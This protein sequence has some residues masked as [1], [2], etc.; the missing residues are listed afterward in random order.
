MQW[1]LYLMAII[2]FFV[3]FFIHFFISFISNV[4]CVGVCVCVDSTIW[5]F[6]KR[7]IIRFIFMGVKY[8]L[9]FIRWMLS[10]VN[11]F[12]RRLNRFRRVI[13]WNTD[14][15]LAFFRTV[16]THTQ[17]AKQQQQHHQP[18]RRLQSVCLK[19]AIET[20]HEYIWIVKC[21]R[22]CAR[23]LLISLEF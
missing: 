23:A 22:W 5:C 19:A 4:L 3:N 15:V 1:I 16:H 12:H 7:Q 13:H 18:K 14:D 21:T 6:F 20:C 11:E 9:I 10:N 17:S 2:L 8:L